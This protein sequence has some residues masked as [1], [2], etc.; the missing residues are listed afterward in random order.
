MVFHRSLSPLFDNPKLDK[1]LC[2]MLRENFAEF[3]SNVEG[4]RF[5]EIF[6][7]KKLDV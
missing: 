4:E 6:L 3:C 5:R 7:F 2:A 1:E